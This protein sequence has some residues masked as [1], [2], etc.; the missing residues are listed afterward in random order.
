[1]SPTPPLLPTKHGLLPDARHLVL[2]E[3][4]VSSGWPAVQRTCAEIGILFDDWQ[5]DL[6][7]CLLAKT[8]SGEYAADM[9][10]FSIP[11]QVGKTFDV[12]AV[13]FADSIIVPGTTTIWTAHR[14]KVA[15]ESFNELR[16]LARSPKLTPHIDYDAVTTA[17]GN[18]C[19]PFRNGSRILFAARERGAIRGFSKVRRLV[20]DEAQILTDAVLADIAPTMNQANNPQIILMGTP[21]K[22]T[23]PG[24]VFTTIRTEALAG[25]SEG[26]LYV[27][28]SADEDCDTDDRA[29][30]RKANFSFPGRTT[31]KAILR[32]RKLLSTDDFRREALGIWNK[33]ALAPKSVISP[34]AWRE[35]EVAA[36]PTEGPVS[37]GVKFSPDG[38]TVAL[39][40]AVQAYGLIHV[41]GVD[42]RLLS[43]GT[44]WLLE[45]LAARRDA[46][47][48]MI[49]G[50]AGAGA[51]ARQLV[52][53]YPARKVTQ[54]STEQATSAY[55]MLAT[56]VSDRTVTHLPDEV[57]A[58]SVGSAGRRLIGTAGGWGFQSIDGGDI[59]LTE[60]IALAH[61]GA[62]T[63]A[64]NKP[65]SGS[66]RKVVVLS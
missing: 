39:A 65:T 10:A 45:W 11:R 15:R 34:E 8:S 40:A 7:R 48:V 27:E 33:A 21:P 38:Q 43:E 14:F 16:A 51:F 63:T 41:E 18:E 24:E 29:A 64:P 66:G 50:K 54:A 13:V 28:L 44:A 17:A 61:Y 5:R 55:A 20:L 6:N 56:A 4:I 59:T 62:A 25:N 1:M 36:A 52:K 49:D 37:Y 42:H 22:P 46:K 19:I 3:G 60:A 35:L 2:P 53:R 12:G 58:E 26:V 57:L 47:V 9:V 32:L 23:D 30:W 31:E